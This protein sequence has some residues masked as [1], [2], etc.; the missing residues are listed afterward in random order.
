MPIRSRLRWLSAIIVILLAL[1]AGWSWRKE[2]LFLLQPERPVAEVAQPVLWRISKAGVADSWLFGTQHVPDGRASLLLRRIEPQ[3]GSARLLLTE[4]AMFSAEEEAAMQAFLYPRQDRARTVLASDA[5][6]LNAAL[7]M[8]QVSPEVQ[9]TLDARQTFALLYLYHPR[10]GPV[11]DALIATRAI[12]QGQPYRG[13][14]TMAGMLA[15]F[16][17]LSEEEAARLSAHY[18]AHSGQLDR[19][20]DEMTDAYYQ[21]SLGAQHELAACSVPADLA[22]LLQRL[23]R[24]LLDERNRAWLPVLLPELANGN[25]F[26][27]VGYMH[28]PRDTGVVALLRKAGYTLTPVY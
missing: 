14:E 5:A 6:A 28:L 13:L 7:R 19:C 9:A 12:T 21:R 26:V 16:D 1:L 25:V 4:H 22:Q 3:L 17:V 11:L 24:A 18:L 23:D 20:V 2:L 10:R 27:A 15:V 8:R